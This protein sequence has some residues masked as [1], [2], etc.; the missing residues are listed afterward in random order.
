MP[1]ITQRDLS[2]ALRARSEKDHRAQLRAAL[3]NPGLSAEQRQDIQLRLSQIGQP[4]VYDAA[5]PAVPGAIRFSPPEEERTLKQ[6]P[7][8]TVEPVDPA[9]I[10]GMKKADLQALATQRGLPSEGTR[11]EIIKR[12]L[13]AQE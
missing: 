4:K 2:A 11:A 5:A 7:K 6:L 8:P 1:F 9:E 10:Q 12:L 3:L 13:S